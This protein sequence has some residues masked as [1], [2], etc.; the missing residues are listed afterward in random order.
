MW[1]WYDFMI[2]QERENIYIRD[3][4]HKTSQDVVLEGVGSVT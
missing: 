1:S 4:K 2:S 3:N